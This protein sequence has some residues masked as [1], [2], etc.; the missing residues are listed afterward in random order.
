[1]SGVSPAGLYSPSR[2]SP[3]LAPRPSSND[4]SPTS[5]SLNHYPS[6]EV[7]QVRLSSI[8]HSSQAINAMPPVWISLP[9]CN[10]RLYSVIL[11]FR[12]LTQLRFHAFT[13]P[14]SKH[15]DQLLPLPTFHTNMPT[16]N[17]ILWVTGSAVQPSAGL[18]SS[19]SFHG[20]VWRSGRLLLS[21][22]LVQAQLLSIQKLPA[23]SRFKSHS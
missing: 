13:R 19:H 18:P 6:K 5:T 14:P 23:Q 3:S 21:I 2:D 22:P 10:S 11:H 16:Q 9:A 8:A 1:M 12:F 20:E 15:T 17:Q 4:P 7:A